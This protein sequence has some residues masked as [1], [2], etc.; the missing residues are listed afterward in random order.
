MDLDEVKH[1]SPGN[2]SLW[3]PSDHRL[4][5]LRLIEEPRQPIRLTYLSTLGWLGLSP[6]DVHFIMGPASGCQHLELG[7]SGAGR[8]SWY[9][10]PRPV[11]VLSL[12]INGFPGAASAWIMDSLS[13][14]E[15]FFYA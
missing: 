6:S 9:Q 11:L 7:Q 5:A 15:P 3:L 14:G 13:A 10:T 12:L 4:P 2:F 8:G 1:S